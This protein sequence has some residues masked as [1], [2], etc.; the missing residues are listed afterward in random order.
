ML[1]AEIWKTKESR[2]IAWAADPGNRS[3]ERKRHMG[4]RENLNPNSYRK[5]EKTG[6]GVTGRGAFETSQELDRRISSLN[7]K[8][9][10]N[11]KNGLRRS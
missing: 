6:N 3:N 8:A 5:D 11:T 9:A 1:G 2:Y 4:G 7:A 10:K